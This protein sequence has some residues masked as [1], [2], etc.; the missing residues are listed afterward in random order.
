MMINRRSNL[1][2]IKLLKQ[3]WDLALRAGKFSQE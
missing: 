2:P 1:I 3:I